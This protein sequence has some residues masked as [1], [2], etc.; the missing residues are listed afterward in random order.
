LVADGG[1]TCVPEGA[2]L[3]V[4]ADDGGEL[5]VHCQSGRHYLDGQLENGK[6]IGLRL[7]VT[8]AE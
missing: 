4:D 8:E 5:F 6:F 3:T 7:A 1:F 2:V